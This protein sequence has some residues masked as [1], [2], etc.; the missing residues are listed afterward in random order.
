MKLGSKHS[1]ESKK[2]ISEH[3]AKPNKGKKLSEETRNKISKSRI[4]IVFS[5]NHINNLKI[6]HIGKKQSPEI[7]EKR[8]SK[9]RGNNHWNWKG[10][11]TS[12]NSKIRMSQ[13][14]KDWRSLVFKRDNWTCVFCGQRGGKL[15]VDHIKPF[16]EYPELRFDT[17]N[18]RVVCVP[19]HRKYG[20]NWGANKMDKEMVIKNGIK[21]G[22]ATL[23]K[24]G[25][26]YFIK[27]GKMKKRSILL[28]GNIKE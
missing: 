23:N 26:E 8:M 13:E 21:G 14:Y 4:G 9:I 19:C 2:K 15:E 3:S 11:I 20:K 28:N 12:L 27:I 24:Y 10:G 16:S 6:S 7:I 22:M 25:K 1:E 18:G 17:N 5:D